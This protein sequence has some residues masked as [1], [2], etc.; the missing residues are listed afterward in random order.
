VIDGLK[1][2]RNAVGI[3]IHTNHRIHLTNSLFADNWLGI[4]IE[5]SEAINVTNTIVIGESDSYRQLMARQSVPIVCLRNKLVGMEL[6]TWQNKMAPGHFISNVTFSDFNNVACAIPKTIS[7]DALVRTAKD[8]LTTVA[9]NGFSAMTHLRSLPFSQRQLIQQTL[10]QGIF[11]TMST[12]QNIKLPDGPPIIDM[13]VINNPEFDMIYIN[14]LNANMRPTSM[15]VAT[16]G[17]ATIIASE[18]N[19]LLKFVDTRLC[20]A[21]PS[22]C[23]SYC[24]DT[25][26]RSLRVQVTGSNVARYK[27]KVCVRGSSPANCILFKAGSRAGTDTEFT[28]MAHLPVGLLYDAVVIDSATGRTVVPASQAAYFEENVCGTSRRFGVALTGQVGAIPF[29]SWVN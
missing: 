9:S 21:V 14:D 7:F 11:E 23:Y 1:A 25:C 19:E 4:D 13:C 10:K 20:V 22:G 5:R 27:L 17:A 3:N 24:R 18:N 28:I 29:V 12:F 2:Y 8:Q 16:T 26:F 6:G 15:T